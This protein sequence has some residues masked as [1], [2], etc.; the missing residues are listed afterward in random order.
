M[1]TVLISAVLATAS[2]GTIAQ[3]YPDWDAR[4]PNYQ[5]YRTQQLEEF[6]KRQRDEEAKNKQLAEDM[7]GSKPSSPRQDGQ[8]G[9]TKGADMRAQGK[10]LLRLPPLPIERNV[11]LGSWRLEGGGPKPGVAEFALTGKGATPGMGELMGMMK[12]LESGKT[13]CD[14]S[15]GGGIS[16]TPTTYSSGGVAGMAG[17]PIAYRSRDTRVIVA[18]PGDTRANPMA[19]EIAGP[20]RIVWGS[21]A[22]VRVRPAAAAYSPTTATTAPG[23]AR[24][25]AAPAR[26]A[27]QMAKAADSAG[28][29]V[30]GAAFRCADGGLLHVSFCQGDDAQ[31]LCKLTELHLPR[32]LGN[33]VPRADI[34]ARVK[35]CEAGGIRYSADDKPVFI[36]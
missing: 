6:N 12:D 36:R 22:L 27:A 30:D 8:P 25:A 1:R 16:F 31:A 10:E 14:V 9:A 20:N 23:N 26:S 3:W 33:M 4:S 29:V 5:Q 24:S 2:N 17:G 13:L 34:A 19:F 7:Y 32:Q 28:A 11:L 18:I 15:F 35:A 21:C